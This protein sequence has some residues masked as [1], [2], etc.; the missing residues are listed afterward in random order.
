VEASL[1]QS[2]I[3]RIEFFAEFP[4][5]VRIALAPKFRLRCVDEGERIIEDQDSDSDVFFVLLGSVCISQCTADGHEL[6]YDVLGKGQLFGEFAAID[7]KPRS[8][9]V[10]A[11]EL[12]ELACMSASDFRSILYTYPDISM[13]VHQRL[14]QVIRRLSLR[15]RRRV[16]VSAQGRICDYIV[17]QAEILKM[18]KRE[19]SVIFIPK[20]AILAAML[21]VSRETIARVL[22]HLVDEKIIVK[23]PRGIR[24]CDEAA[25]K[26]LG[27]RE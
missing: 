21:D 5:S 3:D 16:V 9:A 2:L 22:G 26:R 12:T 1:S 20:Q 19:G 27:E 23:E 4:E 14:V 7:H 25:L 6:I 13:K 10:R 18:E 15:L 17:E 11:A 24:L 8:A